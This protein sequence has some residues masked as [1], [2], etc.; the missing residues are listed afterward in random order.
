MDSGVTLVVTGPCVVAGTVMSER[1]RHLS[2][3]YVDL[4]L[5]YRLLDNAFLGFLTFIGI[6]A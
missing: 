4:L 2:V 5:R 1:D 6:E 3:S